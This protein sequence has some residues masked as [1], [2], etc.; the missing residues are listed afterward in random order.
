MVMTP[1]VTNMSQTHDKTHSTVNAAESR[2]LTEEA[3]PD[4]DF[5]LIAG[6]DSWIQ[7]LF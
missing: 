2:A 6:F 5:V 1:N 7:T 4:I 3:K